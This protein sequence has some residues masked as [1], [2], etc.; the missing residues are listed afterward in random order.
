MTDK[1]NAV[2]WQHRNEDMGQVDLLRILVFLSRINTGE[3]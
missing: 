3:K 1:Y 2:K